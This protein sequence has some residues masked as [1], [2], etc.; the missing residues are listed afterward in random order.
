MFCHKMYLRQQT[1]IGHIE[2]FN[3][4][5]VIYYYL[6]AVKMP[7]KCSIWLIPADIKYHKARKTLTIAIW[8]FVPT[9]TEASNSLYLHWSGWWIWHQ[10]KRVCQISCWRYVEWHGKQESLNFCSSPPPLFDHFVL[11]TCFFH[12]SLSW[13]WLG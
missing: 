3:E 13:L 7:S 12:R 2:L 1:I 4:H 11:P 5:S 6:H 8:R 9:P 10:I